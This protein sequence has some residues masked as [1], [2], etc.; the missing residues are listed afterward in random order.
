M[1]VRKEVHSGSEK[2]FIFVFRPI[3]VKK[4]IIFCGFSYG[5]K[6]FSRTQRQSFS[7]H[8]SDQHGPFHI[9]ACIRLKAKKRFSKTPDQL[10]F[11]T[12]FRRVLN[13]YNSFQ[14]PKRSLSTR[15]EVSEDRCAC[16]QLQR[17]DTDKS[18]VLEDHF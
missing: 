16:R 12:V 8:I 1:G 10:A 18:C 4:S 6:I 9:P 2:L 7:T 17:L 11:Q 14:R 13:E 5:R 15:P 3:H